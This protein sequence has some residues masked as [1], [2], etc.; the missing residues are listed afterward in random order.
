[1]KFFSAL[2]IGVL[3][4]MILLISPV[5]ANGDDARDMLIGAILGT[6]VHES[7]HHFAASKEEMIWHGPIL[8]LRWEYNGKPGSYV[9]TIKNGQSYRMYYDYDQYKRGLEGVA[10]S[11]IIYDGLISHYLNSQSIEN[12]FL[13]N[14]RKGFVLRNILNNVYCLTVSRN[15]GDLDPDNFTSENNR[16]IF[17]RIVAVDT[18]LLLYEFIA[19]RSLLPRGTT[20]SINRYRIL[21]KKRW[22]F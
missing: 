1:M 19:K 2:L 9:S 18:G 13:K 12:K 7:A 8:S 15:R 14:V 11:G 3:L 6:V 20:V 17:K 5:F 10:R 22:T 4:V 21:L 16:K